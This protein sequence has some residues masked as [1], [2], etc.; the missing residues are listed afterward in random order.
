MNYRGDVRH[1]FSRLF[2]NNSFTCPFTTMTNILISL[3]EQSSFDPSIEDFI[4][5][6]PVDSA[7]VIDW[8]VN[9]ILNFNRVS[10]EQDS[11]V[12]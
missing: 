6:D 8:T 2:L 3:I 9:Q 4:E 12:R 1:P 11:A 10:N 7:S 5:I